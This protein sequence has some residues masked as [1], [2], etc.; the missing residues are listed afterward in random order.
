MNGRDK[1]L[2]QAGRRDQVPRRQLQSI[3]RKGGEAQIVGLPGC[4]R[5]AVELLDLVIF[6]ACTTYL[7]AFVVRIQAV[8][9]INKRLEVVY[10]DHLIAR[11]LPAILLNQRVDLDRVLCMLCQQLLDS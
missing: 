10:L 4:G 9:I 3:L 5:R 6:A 8:I 7:F 2:T 11:A 1:S